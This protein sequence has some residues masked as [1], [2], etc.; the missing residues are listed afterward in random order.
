M[1]DKVQILKFPQ[2]G[3]DRGE[4]VVVEGN[5]SIPFEIKRIFYIYGSDPDTIRGQHANRNTKF[6]FINI[7]G[8]SRIKV[9]D[10]R[11]SQ[12]EYELNQPYVGLYVPNPF[13]K[14]M[15]EF[16]EESILLVLA[17]EHY[18]REEYIRDYDEY[19][20]YMKN[21]TDEE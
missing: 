14:E 5:S 16:S 17:S 1:L 2:L 7:A 15:Y 13:W 6:V 10:G 20:Q 4:L 3:D 11:G 8:S 12:E 9:D 21:I 19:V 18:D